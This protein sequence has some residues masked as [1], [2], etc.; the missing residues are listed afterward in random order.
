[1]KE[2]INGL[3]GEDWLNCSNELLKFLKSKFQG[4]KGVIRPLK[5][6]YEK[7]RLESIKNTE[8][9]FLQNPNIENLDERINAFTNEIL[10]INMIPDSKMRFE[11]PN[12]INS[13]REFEVKHPECFY[14]SK[15]LLNNDLSE[16]ARLRLNAIFFSIVCES[17]KQARNTNAGKAGEIFTKIIFDFVGLKEGTDYK[18]QHKSKKGSDTDFVFPYVENYDDLNVEIFMEVQLSSNDRSRLVSSGLKTGAKMYFVTGNGLDASTKKLNDIGAQI[19]EDLK[20]KN[21]QLVCYAPEIEKEKKE[22]RNKILNKVNP[23]ENTEKLDYINSAITFTEL[24]KRLK[25]RIN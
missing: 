22:L 20:N 11:L 9:N 17:L 4:V 16:N 8:K 5:D 14:I 19:V 10:R 12:I 3:D 6:I 7:E 21:I 1:M 13:K 24:A 2:L 15:L 18:K 25:S 23:K